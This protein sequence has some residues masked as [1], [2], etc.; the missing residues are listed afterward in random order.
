MSS[1]AFPIVACGDDALRVLCGAGAIRHELARRLATDRLWIEVVPGREDITVSFDLHTMR[2]VA[3]EARLAESINDQRK[4]A[5]RKVRTHILEAVFGG[6]SGPDLSSL[7][8]RIG[9]PE[10]AIVSEVLSASLTVDMLG[11]TPG[12]AYLS[13][14]SSDI[15]SERLA[16]PRARV[17][18]GSIG[19]ITGQIGLY[20]L[21]GPGGWPIVGRILNPLFDR[22]RTE[23]FVLLAGDNVQLRQA[24][25]A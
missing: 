10:S 22:E 25:A 1:H 8:E 6:E 11:F 7:A 24:A 13:G 4:C 3:A 18:A 23:P 17:A 9:R 16:H 19:L 14:L 5:P 15:V 12:F 20:A 2:M 21:D